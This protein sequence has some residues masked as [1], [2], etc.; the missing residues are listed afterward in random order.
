MNLISLDENRSY[1]LAEVV[2]LVQKTLDSVQQT[3]EQ[4]PLR[5]TTTDVYWLLH[6]MLRYVNRNVPGEFALRRLKR[7]T[8]RVEYKTEKTGRQKAKRKLQADVERTSAYL[9]ELT[10]RKPPRD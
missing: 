3:S 5:Y 7:G 9:K 10:G 6:D 1:T 4:C 2:T 8:Y